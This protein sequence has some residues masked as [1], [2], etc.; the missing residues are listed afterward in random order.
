LGRFHGQK[1]IPNPAKIAQKNS[2]FYQVFRVEKG[3]FASLKNKTPKPPEG[4]FEEP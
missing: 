2:F 4:G 1:V 3:R